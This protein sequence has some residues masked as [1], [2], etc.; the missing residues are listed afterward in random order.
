M[1]HRQ[2]H[3]AG[4]QTDA[5]ADPIDKGMLVS[6]ARQLRRKSSP[7]KDPRR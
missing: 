4:E 6:T 5:I 2:G 7:H 3:Q 1:K